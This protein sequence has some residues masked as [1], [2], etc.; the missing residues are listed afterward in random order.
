MADR[1]G[2]LAVL[3]SK[4]EVA[5]AEYLKAYQGLDKSLDYRRL[6]EAKLASLGAAVPED[7]AKDAAKDAAKESGK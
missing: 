5:K 6:V 2:D 1:R 7:T 3:Q 4:P